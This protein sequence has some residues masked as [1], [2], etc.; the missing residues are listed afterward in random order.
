MAM[1]LK[2]LHT[3]AAHILEIVPMWDRFC[4]HLRVRLASTACHS[5]CTR[6]LQ[7]GY[8]NPCTLK[9]LQIH[10]AAIAHAFPWGTVAAGRICNM[11]LL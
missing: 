4:R 5:Y 8:C 2:Q 10:A 3:V 11:H 6:T 9:L 7:C 1:G